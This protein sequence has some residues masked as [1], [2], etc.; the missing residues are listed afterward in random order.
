VS[1]LEDGGYGAGFWFH[2]VV[3]VAVPVQDTVDVDV[4]DGGPGDEVAGGRQGMAQGV[5][6]ENGRLVHLK[7]SGYIFE[8]ARSNLQNVRQ[9]VDSHIE[10]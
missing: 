7:D 9:S 10:H 4:V 6:I 5:R 2:H 8:S 1:S 3:W